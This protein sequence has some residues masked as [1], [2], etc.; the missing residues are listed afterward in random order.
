MSQPRENS[1]SGRRS[2][3]NT[4]GPAPSKRSTRSPT[5]QKK[6]ARQ[7]ASSRKRQRLIL[8][9]CCIP[10]RN[11]KIG[12]AQRFTFRRESVGSAEAPVGRVRFGRLLELFRVPTAAGSSAPSR[13]D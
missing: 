12:W 3:E 7:A 13:L 8:W 4:S 11:G 5:L 1:A 10:F 2:A 6:S 9:F